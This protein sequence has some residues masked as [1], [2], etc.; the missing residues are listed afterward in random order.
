MA[1]ASAD[2]ALPRRPRR[3]LKLIDIVMVVVTVAI[4]VFLSIILI[5]KLRLKHEVSTA[6]VVS[7]RVLHDIVSVNAKDARSLGDQKF[8]ADH[9][10]AEL[11]DLFK[12]ASTYARGTP[13]L[14]R[15]M[16]NN[17][18][19][20]QAVTFVYRYGSSKPYYFQIEVDKP[21][22]ANNWQL[23]GISGG[24]SVTGLNAR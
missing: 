10:A 4:I 11:Q 20:G 18:D 8:Q 24:N 6:R 21:A 13:D 1:D 17:G 2:S 23:A 5:G 9:S 3:G 19:T 22:H 14:E 16:V 7:D 15:Q 12:N